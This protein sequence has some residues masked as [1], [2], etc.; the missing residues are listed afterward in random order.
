MGI[1]RD[2]NFNKTKLKTKKLS[3]AEI[4]IAVANF[5]NYRVNLIVPNIWWGLN[6]CYELDLI[7]VSKAGY[8]TEVEIKVSLS[9]LKK[10]KLKKEWAHCDKRIKYLFFAIPDYLYDKAVEHIP[11][12]AGILTVNQNLKVDIKKV[13]K[14]NKALKLTQKEILKLQHLSA[15]RIWALKKKIIKFK[16]KEV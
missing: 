10:N 15:M 6:F 14:Q 3:T 16:K 5:L 7:S 9:D 13:A 11:E 1:I 4:E 2:R 8:A 12:N